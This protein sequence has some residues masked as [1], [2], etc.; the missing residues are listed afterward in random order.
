MSPGIPVSEGSGRDPGVGRPAASSK[1]MIGRRSSGAVEPSGFPGRASG[2]LLQGR[3]TA[4]GVNW[5]RTPTRRL[6]A[7]QLPSQQRGYAPGL[8][9]TRLLACICDVLVLWCYSLPLLG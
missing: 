2:A 3:P 9:L 1:P 6:K 5:C 4:L 7:G 8:A